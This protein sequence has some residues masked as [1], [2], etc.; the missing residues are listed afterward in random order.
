MILMHRKPYNRSHNYS[1]T[2]IIQIL[3]EIKKLSE[4]DALTELLDSVSILGWDEALKK[5]LSMKK[6]KYL[7][8]HPY[9]IFFS[10]PEGLWRTYISND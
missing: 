7:S 5:I 1:K 8:Q 3:Q 10:E 6:E 2:E 4:E 9:K